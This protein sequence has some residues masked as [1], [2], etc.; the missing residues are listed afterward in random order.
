[1]TTIQQWFEKTRRK[2]EVK[3][4]WWRLNRKLQKPIVKV[5][6]KTSEMEKTLKKT[7]E[8]MAKFG[9]AIGKYEQ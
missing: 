4:V 7:A 9:Q 6:V 3:I 5:T 1:M 8:A 2:I